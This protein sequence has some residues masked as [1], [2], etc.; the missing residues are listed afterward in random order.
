MASGQPTWQETSD[1]ESD[2]SEQRQAM[3]DALEDMARAEEARI[4]LDDDD[5]DDDDDDEDFLDADED[6][7]EE[8]EEFDVEDMEQVVGDID[9]EAEDD[10]EDEDD[11]EEEEEEDDDDDDDGQPTL[12]GE[13]VPGARLRE[14]H[15][16]SPDIDFS[17]FASQLLYN[18]CCQAG[19]PMLT[20]MV[21]NP[22]R[23]GRRGQSEALESQDYGNCW[24]KEVSGSGQ[25]P[26]TMKTM[27]T[28]GPQT[29]M[30][31]LDLPACKIS[32]N[33]SKSQ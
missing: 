30:E 18:R 11:V 19:W 28:M 16:C 29:G 14:N 25:M 6:E 27:M 3:V 10:E 26:M 2:S 24:H 21:K 13:V 20:R 17:P 7:D 15:S 1:A 23:A 5:E 4:F 9:I 31:P 12:A 33:R 22:L 8:D 32:G